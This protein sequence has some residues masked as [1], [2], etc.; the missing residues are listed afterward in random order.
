[1]MQMSLLIHYH[2]HDPLALQGI[3]P[4]AAMW[5]GRDKFFQKYASN[6]TRLISTT[7]CRM[8]DG[9]VAATLT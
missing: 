8:F 4:F 9:P 2:S 7:I 6:L 3:D 1:M 5:Q